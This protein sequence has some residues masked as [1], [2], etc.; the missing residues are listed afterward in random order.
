LTT[1][2]ASV[3]DHRLPPATPSFKTRIVS[4]LLQVLA[5][6]LPTGDARIGRAP[7]GTSCQPGPWRGQTRRV[8]NGDAGAAIPRS[9]SSVNARTTT[10][11]ADRCVRGDCELGRHAPRTPGLMRTSARSPFADGSAGGSNGATRAVGAMVTVLGE[12][13][14]EGVGDS[15]VDGP[16]TPGHQAAQLHMVAVADE[17]WQGV[18]EV[19]MALTTSARWRGPGSRSLPP[20]DRA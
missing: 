13:L 6:V 8:S 10:G 2:L 15:A 16:G 11:T 18:S 17:I 1:G 4:L 5:G 14:A 20:V 3:R 7:S 9:P 19:A 12:Q